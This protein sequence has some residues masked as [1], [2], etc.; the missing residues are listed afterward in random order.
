MLWKNLKKRG[1]VHRKVLKHAKKGRGNTIII[2]KG[3]NN[4]VVNINVPTS[5]IKHFKKGKMCKVNL[6]VKKAYIE[7]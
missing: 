5:K 1:Y 6:K 3:D 7:E 2:V 4:R